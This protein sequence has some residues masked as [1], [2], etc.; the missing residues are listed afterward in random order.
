MTLVDSLIQLFEYTNS[1]KVL[2]RYLIFIVLMPLLAPII[3]IAMLIML[4]QT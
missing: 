3:V 4:I 2:T 1:R